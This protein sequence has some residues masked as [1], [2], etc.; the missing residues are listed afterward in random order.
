MRLLHPNALREGLYETGLA[1]YVRNTCECSCGVQWGAAHGWTPTNRTAPAL[2]ESL[3]AV[4]FAKPSPVTLTG[5]R[6]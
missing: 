5:I 1:E 3:G 4:L 6:P 2:E